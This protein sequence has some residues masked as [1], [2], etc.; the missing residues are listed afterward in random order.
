MEETREILSSLRENLENKDWHAVRTIV[1]DIHPADAL[2]LITELR[3]TERVVVFRLLHK[4]IA[5]EVFTDLPPDQQ[6]ILLELFTESQTAKI[7]EEMDPDDRADV[8]EEFPAGVVRELLSVISP[9][10]RDMTA[11][12]LG[13]P[14]NSAGRI[15]TPEYVEIRPRMKVSEALDHIRKTGQNK[16]SIYICYVIGPYRKLKGVVSLRDMLFAHPDALIQDIMTSDPT[17]ANTHDDQEDAASTAFKY[18]LIALPVV[19]NEDRLVGIITID[20]LLDVVEEEATEDIHRMAAMEQ[21]PESYFNTR[22]SVLFRNRAIWL[23]MLMVAQSISG[24]ILKHYETAL[25]TVVALIFFVPMLIGSAGNTATQSATLV[26]R[27]LA[28]GEIDIGG[29]WKVLM[30]ESLMGV[31]LGVLLGLVGGLIA[32]VMGQ[33]PRMFV[34][35]TLAFMLT[36]FFANIV[37]AF[38]PLVFK[39][40]GFDPAI[41]AGPAITTIIDITGLIIYFS[42][43]AVVF[44]LSA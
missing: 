4:R 40:I 34:A 22:L 25:T 35:V 14:E 38:L 7:F 18:D 20:D 27:G 17:K 37:G 28:V 2:E 10:E 15:M 31:M 16:E 11:R 12:L 5:A 39:R 23:L 30:R 6:S 19:D 29:I 13:Y 36:I 33:D 1:A 3:T 9:E 41:T 21:L 24:V 44:N 26:I 43:A 42:I 8:L 32:Y